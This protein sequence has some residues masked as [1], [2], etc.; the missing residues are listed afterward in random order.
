LQEIDLSDPV[1]QQEQ[2]LVSIEVPDQINLL[3]VHLL[4]QV[5]SEEDRL[6]VCEEAVLLDLEVAFQEVLLFQGHVLLQEVLEVLEA[7]VPEVEAV[8]PEVQGEAA[9]AEAQEALAEAQEVQDLQD[10]DL[11]EVVEEEE[12]NNQV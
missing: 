3:E 5:P 8:A 4:E 9:E 10:Y 7:V 12:D 11:Q 6:Q 2:H 1:E